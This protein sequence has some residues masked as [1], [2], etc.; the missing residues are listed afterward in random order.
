MLE[1]FRSKKRLIK[2]ISKLKKIIENNDNFFRK[3][4]N[5]YELKKE[6][7]L[8]LNRKDEQHNKQKKLIYEINAIADL[9]GMDL[10]NENDVSGTLIC[11]PNSL[12]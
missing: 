6:E 8:E 4:Y 5:K 9:I 2:E 12:Y 7:L 10:I 1:W 11:L 3:S